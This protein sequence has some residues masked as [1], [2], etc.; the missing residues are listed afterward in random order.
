MPVLGGEIRTQIPVKVVEVNRWTKQV[1]LEFQ[2][3]NGTT[4]TV[5]EGDTVVLGYALEVTP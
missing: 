5:R 1:T 3:K 2:L 4:E